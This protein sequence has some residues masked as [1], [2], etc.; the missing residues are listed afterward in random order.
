MSKTARRAEV[1]RILSA[2]QD[3]A[4]VVRKINEMGKAKPPEPSRVD[5]RH[6][7]EPIRVEPIPQP[8]Q[9]RP[10]PKPLEPEDKIMAELVRMWPMLTERDRLELQGIAQLKVYLNSKK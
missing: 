1:D 2:D 6:P 3:L 4:F 5:D 7:P 9:I 10:E 8:V